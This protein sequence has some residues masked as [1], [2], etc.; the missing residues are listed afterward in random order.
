[1]IINYRQAVPEVDKNTLLLLH[2]EDL[3]DSSVYKRS[4]Q[5]H[6]NVVSSSERS[7]FGNKSLYFDENSYLT[8]SDIP[9]PN[10]FENFTIDWWQYTLSSQ[11]VTGVMSRAYI[12]GTGYGLLIG[13]MDSMAIWMSSESQWDISSN[14]SMGSRV[15][16]EWQHFAVVRLG[17]RIMLFNNGVKVTEF[18]SDLS[19]DAF[20]GPLYIGEYD[21]DDDS[22][23]K[24]SGYIDELRISRAARWTSDFALPTSPYI[25]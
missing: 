22:D 14:I 3:S 8:I 15:Y 6:G 1:M 2:G 20:G 17:N 25:S 23:S 13:H 5:N 12:P 11:Q 21:Y 9:F 10:G 7:K 24:F 18:T 4:I 19:F 16:N